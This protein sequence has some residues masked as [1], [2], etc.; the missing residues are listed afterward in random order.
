MD[1]CPDVVP[2][3]LRYRYLV[4]TGFEHEIIV[5]NSLPKCVPGVTALE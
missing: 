3:R 1:P 4:A 5:T 2:A